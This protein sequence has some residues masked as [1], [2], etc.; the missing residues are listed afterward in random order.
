MDPRIE[1]DLDRLTDGLLSTS[2]AFG[3]RATDNDGAE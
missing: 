2:A 1:E 3:G